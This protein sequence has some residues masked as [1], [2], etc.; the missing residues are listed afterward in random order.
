MPEGKEY[1]RPFEVAALLGVNP[2][3][4]SRWAKE[5]KL[6]CQQTLGGNTGPGHF[7]FLRSDVKKILAR[8]DSSSPG[9]EPS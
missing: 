4:V 5:G 7:R 6:P 3:T 2:R 9:G 1:L 8:L